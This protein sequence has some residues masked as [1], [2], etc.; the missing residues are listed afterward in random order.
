MKGGEYR[1]LKLNREALKTSLRW[2]SYYSGFWNQA[3][4][5][6]DSL[7]KKENKDGVDGQ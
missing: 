4:D 2:I 1:I 7:I 3:F 6:R 5:N